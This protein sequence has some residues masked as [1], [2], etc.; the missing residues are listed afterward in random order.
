MYFFIVTAMLAR[1]NLVP[2]HV[3]GHWTSPPCAGTSN[4]HCPLGQRADGPVMGNG[5]LGAMLG[6]RDGGLSFWLTKNDFWNLAIEPRNPMCRYATYS[7]KLYVPNMT[8]DTGCTINN[9]SNT[10]NSQATAGGLLL[11]ASGQNITNWTATQYFENAT[12]NG[13][14]NMNAII[15]LCCMLPCKLYGQNFHR[16]RLHTQRR[17][18]IA[19]TE[20]RRGTSEQPHCTGHAAIFLHA[21]VHIMCHCLLSKSLEYINIFF[22]ICQACLYSLCQFSFLITTMTA[23]AATSINISTG[24]CMPPG[25]RCRAGT[26]GVAV[27][28]STPA[29]TDGIRA[30]KGITVRTKTAIKTEKTKVYTFQNAKIFL[31]ATTL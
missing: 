23:S 3:N 6:E 18:D 25:A 19:N 17:V 22:S 26:W 28:A 10:R 31:H 20:L 1:S 9:G 7:Q 21:H 24:S 2:E 15:G 14:S 4:R 12:V 5:D 30:G 27:T 13:K 8:L 16:R 29:P 11:A